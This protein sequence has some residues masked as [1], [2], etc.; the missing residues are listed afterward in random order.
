MNAEAMSDFAPKSPYRAFRKHL[1]NIQQWK[2]LHGSGCRKQHGVENLLRRRFKLYHAHEG[3]G[4]NM[5]LKD[6]RSAETRKFFE[7]FSRN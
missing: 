6:I 1:P 4:V 3:T 7:R 2:I 5:V